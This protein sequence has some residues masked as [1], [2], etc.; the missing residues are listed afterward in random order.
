MRRFHL[1]LAALTAA[2]LTLSACGNMKQADLGGLA[3]AGATAFKAATLSDADVVAM[4]DGWCEESDKENKRAIAPANNKYAQRLD[5]VVKGMPS[6]VN[7]KPASY[8]VYL[9]KDVN[10]W[11]MANG[12]I[13]VYSGLMDLMNDDELR[14]VLGHEIGHVALGHTKASMQT[15]YAAVAARQVA[16][17]SGNG[18][19]AGLSK[20]QLGDMAQTVLQAQFSQSQESA[21]DDYSFDLLTERKMDRKGLVTA[22]QKLAKL[23]GGGDGRSLTSSH[24]PST[25]RAERMLKR[26]DA[27]QQASK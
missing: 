16:A 27:S 8:K 9:T 5:K 1:Q 10:A 20:S 19:I 17:S 25:A 2:I 23:D 7:G 15:A 4:A 13:R 3:T 6:T 18:A 22:F 26:L 12:C 24:P 14:G 11:A 21:A